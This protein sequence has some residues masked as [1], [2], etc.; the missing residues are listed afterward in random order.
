MAGMFCS[1]VI[2]VDQ[3]IKSQGTAFFNLAHWKRLL[4]S[5]KMR[6]PEVH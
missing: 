6:S 4:V 5:S 3:V 1:Y 2:A